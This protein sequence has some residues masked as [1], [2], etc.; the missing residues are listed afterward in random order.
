MHSVWRW[1][2][3][4][5]RGGVR[6]GHHSQQR[7]QGRNGVYAAGL[8]RRERYGA[9][10][11]GARGKQCVY[12]RDADG[13]KSIYSHGRTGGLQVCHKAGSGLHS[14][15]AGQGGD[16]GGGCGLVY[17]ASGQRAYHRVSRKEAQGGHRTI[18]DEHPQDWQYV[19]RHD[20]GT[21]R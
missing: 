1:R 15:G 19:L 11:R 13:G 3:C 17:A 6:G 20:T 7:A 5:V 10:L 9:L 8:R 14:A 16:D 18:S 2:R 4:G 12:V 21:A